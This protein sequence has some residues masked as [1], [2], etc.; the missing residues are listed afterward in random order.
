M[1]L[2]TLPALK[3][4][5]EQLLAVELNVEIEVGIDERLESSSFDALQNGQES[6]TMIG[7]NGFEAL[8]RIEDDAVVGLE[9]LDGVQAS[10]LDVELKIAALGFRQI[11]SRLGAEESH[12]QLR[13]GDNSDREERTIHGSQ[14]THES[15]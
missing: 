10:V 9:L 15:S 1:L 11:R 2:E 14:G 5:I 4:L 13:G 8:H 12:V 6:F 7:A 3:G